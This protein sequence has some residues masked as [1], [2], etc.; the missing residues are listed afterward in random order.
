MFK[1]KYF[2]PMIALTFF[3]SGITNGQDDGLKLL[4][5][6][7]LPTQTGQKLNVDAFAGNVKIT[8]WGK[9]EVAVKI[10]GDTNA[11][12][13][14]QFEV[15]SESS[16]IKVDATQKTDKKHLNNINLK[17]EIMAPFDYSVKVS[18]GGGNVTLTDQNGAVEIST[19]G[20]NVSL[21]K[22]KGDVDVSTA[23][24]NITVDENTGMLKLSTAGGNITAKN[25]SGE[26]D[27]STAGGNVNLT[28]SSGKVSGSTAGGN[29]KLDF[30]GKNY[31]IDL[32]TMAGQITLDLPADFDADADL[33]T[34]VGKIKCDFYDA[35]GKKEPSNLKTKLNNGGE[36][37]KCSTM[38]GDIRV[39]KK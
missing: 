11:E 31:G 8:S 9:N 29:I 34:M 5:E 38:A 25:F 30:S 18:T 27:A 36:P 32:S 16:G 7:S 26:V 35:G 4:L 10:Y 13:N 17:M 28:G 12:E 1:L 21:G 39:N 6:K 33:T 15:T 23:G 3:A 20:G 14:L 24:G 22:I 37:L 2:L 19:L